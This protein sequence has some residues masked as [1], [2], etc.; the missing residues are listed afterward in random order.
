MK[1]NGA[2]LSCM[3]LLLPLWV[4]IALCT[5]VQR[6]AAVQQEQCSTTAGPMLTQAKAPCFLQA[7][8]LIEAM[9]YRSGHHSTSDDSSRWA[10]CC[11]D[12]L[13]FVGS[14]S[15]MACSPEL[16]LLP[17][18]LSAD[19][20]VDPGCKHICHSLPCPAQVPRR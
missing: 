8:V 12:A 3:Q 10:G 1:S 15:G 9:S 2:E 16:P 7:P 5:G 17:L 18:G 13:C 20:H 4:R 19:V 11:F 14:A 6:S